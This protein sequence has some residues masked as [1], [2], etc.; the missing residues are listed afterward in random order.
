VAQTFARPGSMLMGHLGP[1][2]LPPCRCGLP[3]CVNQGRLMNGSDAEPEIRIN[4]PAALALVIA[5]LA[6]LGT[7]AWGTV[8]AARKASPTSTSWSW[9]HSEG[10]ENGSTRPI[11]NVM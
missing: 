3:F 10:H 8:A 11:V 7:A 5:A 2:W 9:F 1:G 4:A 6:T